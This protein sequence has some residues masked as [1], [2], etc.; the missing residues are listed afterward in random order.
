LLEGYGITSSSN[1]YVS[2]VR[3]F[4]NATLDPV[5]FPL[6]AILPKLSVDPAAPLLVVLI[7]LV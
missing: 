1:S 2:V 4:F 5:L 3:V 6:R 7:L